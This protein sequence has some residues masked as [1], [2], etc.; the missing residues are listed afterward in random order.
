[1]TTTSIPSARASAT[2]STAVTA[3]STV[4]SRLRAAR[5]QPLDRRAREPVAVVDPAR[6][7]P[8]DVRAERAQRAHE[9]RGRA[10]AVDVVVAVDGDPRAALDVLEDRATPPPPA[11]ARRRAGARSAAARNARAA[12]GSPSPRR[13]STC[14][15]TCEQ[16]SSAASRAAAA[17]SYGVTCRRA[18][19]M[20]RRLG[21]R[22]DG[23]RAHSGSSD[24]GPR[25]CSTTPRSPRSAI[26]T[27][28]SASTAA[29]STSCGGSRRALRRAARRAR[30]VRRRPRRARCPTATTAF[31]DVLCS[32]ARR[33]AHAPARD[34]RRGRP[35]AAA[36]RA[37]RRA[38]SRA[39]CTPARSAAGSRPTTPAACGSCAATSRSRRAFGPAESDL[40][41][42]LTGTGDRL[43]AVW[44]ASGASDAARR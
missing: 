5:G 37:L 43:W 13:T 1:M 6:Q 2:S 16:P 32:S 44:A 26:S 4:I 7:V 30:R 38:R 25:R 8:V 24:C 33:R 42:S 14:A 28:T 9:D 35:R 18:C 19:T 31:D 34:V 27:A 22:E 17:N 3:Q 15:S 36:R 20:R 10:D 21:A 11:P 39:R 41:T 23:N 29:C 40:R 12:S